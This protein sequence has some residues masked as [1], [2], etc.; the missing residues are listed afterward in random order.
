MTATERRSRWLAGL[1]AGAELS[2]ASAP[3][4]RS[5]PTC[6]GLSP[7][8]ETPTGEADGARGSSCQDLCI[9][10]ST[11]ASSACRPPLGV[12][13]AAT[14]C[15]R[16]SCWGDYYLNLYVTAPDLTPPSPGLPE[17][18]LARCCFR[19]PGNVRELQACSSGALFADCDGSVLLPILAGHTARPAARFPADPAADEPSATSTRLKSAIAL[20][21]S[22]KTSTRTPSGLE[23]FGAAP[24]TS[25]SDAKTGGNPGGQ[26]ANCLQSSTPR[27]SVRT[28]ISPRP[29]ITIAVRL[30]GR[31]SS[32]VTATRTGHTTS[33]AGIGTEPH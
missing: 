33:W 24:L 2:S 12:A 23:Q 16:W 21:P 29:R 20:R 15:G 8:T 28:K 6:R 13:S 10:G 22:R 7:P 5:A 30:D 11:L 14:I 9:S 32:L 3:T 1:L 18:T 4:R 31:R 26:A 17:Y 19:P 25:R 27:Q